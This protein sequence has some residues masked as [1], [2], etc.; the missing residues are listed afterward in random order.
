MDQR[1]GE[2]EDAE[3]EHRYPDEEGCQEGA[4]GGEGEVEGEF[5]RL[6]RAGRGTG[7]VVS[8]PISWCPI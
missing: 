2:E 8:F 1:E 4:E 3:G 7:G 5:P 6:A